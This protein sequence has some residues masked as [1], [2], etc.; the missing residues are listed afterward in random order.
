MFLGLSSKQTKRPK[1]YQKSQDTFGA[2]GEAS[3]ICISQDYFYKLT[4]HD[5]STISFYFLVTKVG[6]EKLSFG[7]E[8][9]QFKID[10]LNQWIPALSFNTTETVK[11]KVTTLTFVV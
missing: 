4:L 3:N 5:L 6:G 1:I 2:N 9:Q 7:I 10:M 8:I 11:R